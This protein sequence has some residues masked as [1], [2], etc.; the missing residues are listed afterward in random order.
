MAAGATSEEGSVV[1]EYREERLL[2]P[3]EKI[4]SLR[5]MTADVGLPRPSVRYTTITQEF[6]SVA[7][8]TKTLGLNR[9]RW[10]GIMHA[11][12]DADLHFNVL[13]QLDQEIHE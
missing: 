10:H 7:I 12:T 2:N 11:C 1:S 13:T 4:I 6:G 9:A 8:R 3:H 5:L